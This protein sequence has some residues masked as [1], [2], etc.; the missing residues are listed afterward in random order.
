MDEP[1]HLTEAHYYAFGY[2]ISTYAKVEQGFKIFIGRMSGMELYAVAII[3]EPYSALQLRNVLTSLNR[4]F[5]LPDDCNKRLCDLVGEFKT[6]SRLRN[7]IG[8]YMWTVGNRP[9]SVK[10]LGMD[11]RSGH[12]KAVGVND[13]ERDWT[14][15]ELNAEAIR[16]QDLHRRQVDLM[17]ELG[18]DADIAE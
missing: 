1:H 14:L 6:F 4:H 16:L 18:Y 5:E 10:P 3:C 2:L 15:E 9:N 17:V 13:Q 7:D 8:H 11:I 12:A